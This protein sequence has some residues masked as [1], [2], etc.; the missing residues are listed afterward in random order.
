[1]F[2]FS[3]LILA[4]LTLLGCVKSLQLLR[5]EKKM[6]VVFQEK[7][8]IALLLISEILEEA[9]ACLYALAFSKTAYVLLGYWT[10]SHGCLCVEKL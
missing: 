3:F 4:Q 6:N 8:K 5:K 2:S 10:L 1:M 9:L 7:I